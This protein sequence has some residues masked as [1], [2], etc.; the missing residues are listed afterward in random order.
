MTY[1]SGHIVDTVGLLAMKRGIRLTLRLIFI[2]NHP[3]MEF[4][5]S[6]PTSVQ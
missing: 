4:I 2:A 5:G 1:S 6:T 3:T